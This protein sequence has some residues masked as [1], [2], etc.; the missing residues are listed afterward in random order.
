[1]A[2]SHTLFSSVI[3]FIFKLRFGNMYRASKGIRAGSILNVTNKISVRLTL[4]E[5]FYCVYVRIYEQI[6]FPSK[7]YSHIYGEAVGQVASLI[8]AEQYRACT[9]TLLHARSSTRDHIHAHV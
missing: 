9:C 3:R 2:H 7:I 8:Y 6:H 5:R 1:M 4:R